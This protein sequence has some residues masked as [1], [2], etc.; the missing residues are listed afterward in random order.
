MSAVFIDNVTGELKYQGPNS[1]PAVLS[2]GYGVVPLVPMVMPYTLLTGVQTADSSVF[3][4]LGARELDPS[5]MFAGNSKITRS[6][7]FRVLLEATT[8]VT[9]EVRLYNLD[10]GSAVSG[11]TLTT[12]SNSP[13]LLT[14]ALT[15]GTA[16]DLVDATQNYELQLRISAP[17]SPGVTDRAICKMAEVVFNYS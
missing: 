13:V 10:T 9:A 2:D 4:G 17:G 16:P 3:A 5:V 12:S 7:E 15:V 1:T 14:A 11:S 6:V 8:G